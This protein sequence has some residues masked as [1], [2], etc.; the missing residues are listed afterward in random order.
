MEID[1]ND[2][3][4]CYKNKQNYY[5][6]SLPYSTVGSILLKVPWKL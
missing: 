2:M 4:I 5:S 1:S 3:Y 6:Y